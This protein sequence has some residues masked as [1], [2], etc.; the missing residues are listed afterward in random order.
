MCA[1][2]SGARARA[3]PRAY[4]ARLELWQGFGSRMDP[5][6]DTNASAASRNR[7][8][9][10]PG[11]GPPFSIQRENPAD[12]QQKLTFGAN[13]GRSLAIPTDRLPLWADNARSV[14]V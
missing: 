5:E 12:P 13:R 11:R 8:R 9:V 6:G 7:L 4:D 14:P 3:F 2:A 10:C 1:T